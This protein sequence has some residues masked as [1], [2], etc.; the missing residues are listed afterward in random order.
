MSDL[1]DFY[2][3][4]LV[5]QPRLGDGAYGPTYGPAVTVQ[6]YREQKRHIVRSSSGDTVESSSVFYTTTDQAA[7][8]P[9]G[10]QVSDTDGTSEVIRFARFES[11]D[12]GLPDHIAVDLT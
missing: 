2:V 4:T 9:T 6:G 5:V 8:F 3:H 7:L 1:Q 12:L 10:S 11:G